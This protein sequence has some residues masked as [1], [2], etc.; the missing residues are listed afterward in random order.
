[1]HKTDCVYERRFIMDKNELEEYKR[2]LALIEAKLT[3]DV[4]KELT[5]EELQEYI[6]LVSKI[7]ARLD[8]LENL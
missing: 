5:R 1:M 8:I 4:V 6:T 3:D 7:K 2:E